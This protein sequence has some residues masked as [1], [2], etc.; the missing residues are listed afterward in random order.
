V[1][2]A[3]MHPAMPAMQ[4]QAAMQNSE[5]MMQ[6]FASHAMRTLLQNGVGSGRQENNDLPSWLKL[7]G[8]DS[9][10][11]RTIDSNSA[12]VDDGDGGATERR[13]DR[14]RKSLEECTKD[15]VQGIKTTKKT[16]S[17]IKIVDDDDD[18]SADTAASRPS[19]PSPK[20]RAKLKSVSRTKDGKE[21][22]GLTYKLCDESTRNCTRIRCSDGSSFSFQYFKYGGRNK[23]LKMAKLWVHN[24]NVSKVVKKKP[25][26]K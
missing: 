7:V 26:R 13:P 6:M 23:T 24:S 16:K 14:K 15:L 8:E 20:G 12:V 22:L 10:S 17:P 4:N 5:S 9:R 2:P 3:T 21:R 25:A 1:H 18:D 19:R 11:D